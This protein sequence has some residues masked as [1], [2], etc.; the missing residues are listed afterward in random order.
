MVTALLGQELAPINAARFGVWLHGHAADLVLRKRGCEEGLTPT[1]LSA[2]L[3][4]ALV[5]LRQSVK[6]FGLLQHGS[7]N[8]GKPPA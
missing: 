6:P 3:G 2:E 1:M 4:A 5:S 8:K 7:E